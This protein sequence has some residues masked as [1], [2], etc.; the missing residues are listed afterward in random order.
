MHEFQPNVM[1]KIIVYGFDLSRLAFYRFLFNPINTLH[2]SHLE[3]NPRGLLPLGFIVLEP[4]TITFT[5][6]LIL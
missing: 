3:F 4:Q 2:R 5:A 6:L 1:V